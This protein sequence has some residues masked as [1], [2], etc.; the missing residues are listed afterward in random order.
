VSA[1]LKNVSTGDK[2]A[3]EVLMKA[4]ERAKTAGVKS[5]Q[6]DARV[7]AVLARGVSNATGGGEPDDL[8]KVIQGKFQTCGIHALLKACAKIASKDFGVEFNSANPLMVASWGLKSEKNKPIDDF[9]I[10]MPDLINLWHRAMSWKKFVYCAHGENAL[11]E[12]KFQIAYTPIEK[13]SEMLPHCGVALVAQK[14]D[15]DIGHFMMVDQ[16]VKTG[17]NTKLICVNSSDDNRIEIPSSEFPV[18]RMGYLLDV[19][20]M[21]LKEQSMEAFK[22]LQRKP[23]CPSPFQPTTY[24][25]PDCWEK[26]VKLVEESFRAGNR[27]LS[28]EEIAIGLN[29]LHNELTGIII[30]PI[31]AHHC[32]VPSTSR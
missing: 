29:L 9:G 22:E 16:V 17:D 26:Q 15:D 20:N 2:A 24:P 25:Q 12:C 8:P 3:M 28:D 30:M 18:F 27:A 19:I 4:L 21:S 1:A 11:V 31:S 13:I 14:R 10:T 6:L 32:L 23:E 5:T 7:L